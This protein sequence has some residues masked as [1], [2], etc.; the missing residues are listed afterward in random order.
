MRVLITIA[1]S[2]VIFSATANLALR[3]ESVP[4][5]RVYTCIVYI[6]NY[7]KSPAMRFFSNGLKNEFETAVVN[8]SLVF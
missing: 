7:S 4:D 1:N 5:K 8:E 3:Q 6:V 2:C